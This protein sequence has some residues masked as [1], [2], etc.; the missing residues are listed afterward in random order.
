[1]ANGNQLEVHER[2]ELLIRL[3]ERT[4][5]VCRELNEIKEQLISLNGTVDYHTAKIAAN[6][7]WRGVSRWLW[8]GLV[9]AIIALFI[10][11]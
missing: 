1:M 8:G 11:N 9:A 10:K 6:S 2:D 5:F 7:T 4:L 3:D